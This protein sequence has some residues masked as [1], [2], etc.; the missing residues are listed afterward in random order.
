M[1]QTKTIDGNLLCCLLLSGYK[2]LNEYIHYLNEINVF[3]VSDKDTGTNMERTYK[4]G[5]Q[6]LVAH[7]S[8]SDVF[9][10]FI[11]GMLLGSRGNS[12]SILSHYFLGIHEYT[13][14]KD[15]ISVMEFCRALQNAYQVAY[16][17]V[18]RPVEGTMLTVMRDSI[19]NTL[20]Q[21]SGE[22]SLEQ[23]F[24]IYISELFSSVKSTTKTL[25]ILRLNNVVDSGAA[26]FY[27]IFDGIKNGL[28]KDSRS[29]VSEIFAFSKDTLNSSVEPLTFR[30]CTEFS[31]RLSEEQSRQHFVDLLSPHGDSLIVSITE[32]ILKVHIHNNTPQNILDEFLQ[33]GEFI[34]TKVDDM[35]IQ[36]EVSQLSSLNLKHKDFVIITFAYGDGVIKLFDELGCDIVFKLSPNYQIREEDFHLFIDKFTDKEIIL[37][38]N[39]ENI[40]NTAMKLYSEEQ[41]PS[42]HIINS[43]N[44][45]KSYFLLCS[46]IGT[47]DISGV[48]K[49]FAEYDG[50]DFLFVRILS[51]S[52]G[53][54]KY[55]IGITK[56]EVVIN[57]S[58]C[59]LLDAVV[60]SP[61]DGMFE[62]FIIFRG[63]NVEDE[64]VETVETVFDKNDDIEFAMLDSE[65]DD[66]DFIIGAM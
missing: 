36:Q 39:D 17:A 2:N 24:E 66:F 34:E 15:E 59:D 65:C 8:F 53:R 45:I 54:E 32:D 62:S 20:T 25:D 35:L 19:E 43:Q 21:V 56:S 4:M 37:F 61:A 30:Y 31:I 57:K 23:F 12:G 60:F 50:T 13:K 49:T 63:Q 18:L 1:N 38:P 47:D 10:L 9:D 6:E 14:G 55:Y 33:F 52:I 28:Y 51:V 48:L 64:D 5:A 3:P 44:I 7:P 41:N 27:L 11:R 29:G 22:T 58:I 26:G 46:M 40:Y 42:I 16:R